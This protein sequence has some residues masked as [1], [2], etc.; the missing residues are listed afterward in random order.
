MFRRLFIVL[1]SV[2]VI[3]IIGFWF[4]WLTEDSWF[5]NYKSFL[6]YLVLSHILYVLTV[7]GKYVVYGNF[8]LYKIPEENKLSPK[9]EFYDNLGR[10]VLEI[11]EEEENKSVPN[12]KKFKPTEQELYETNIKKHFK[13]K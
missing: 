12:E 3:P 7:L 9:E 1:Q 13:V 8:H 10:E 5:W 11:E 2:F 4:V 6:L